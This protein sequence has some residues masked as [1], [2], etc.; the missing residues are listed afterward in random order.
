MTGK[1]WKVALMFV[2]V[3]TLAGGCAAGGE[4]V[5]SSSS[6]TLSQED[7]AAVPGGNLYEVI[8]RLR[9]RW[10][11]IRHTMSMSGNPGQIVVFL[12]S[13]YLGGP[14]QLRQFQARDVLEVRYLDGPQASA[15]LR[16]Y[17]STVHVAGAIVLVTSQR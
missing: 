10:L 2:L 6:T 14:D 11:Q 7:M 9:P 8:D 16:G 13:T 17:D 5:G 12:N 1:F 15:Q 3:G 4:R